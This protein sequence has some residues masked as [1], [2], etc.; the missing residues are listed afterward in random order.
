MPS[1]D[2]R[3]TALK[4]VAETHAAVATLGRATKITV[5]HLQMGV[6]HLERALKEIEHEATWY[7]APPGEVDED[8][9]ETVIQDDKT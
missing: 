5:A 6:I 2:W 9:G 1:Y 8:M 7:P 3:E 4:A